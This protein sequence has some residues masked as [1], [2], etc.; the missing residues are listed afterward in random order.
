MTRISIVTP[1]FN[2]AENLEALYDRLARVAARLDCDWEWVVVDDHSY[3]GSFA[4]VERLARRDPRVRGLRLSRNCG[5]H[6][7]ITCGLHQARGDAAVVLAADLQDPPELLEPLVERWRGGAQVVW[8]ARRTPP[9][10][11]SAL[12]YWM[13]RRVVGMSDMPAYGADVFLI[14]RAPLEAFRRWSE[15]NVTVLGLVTWLGYRQETI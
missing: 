6:V 5:S 13:M 3:D 14:D 12:Y 15:R 2:E 8:A 4:C 7:A 11:F 9:T 10:G 1:A